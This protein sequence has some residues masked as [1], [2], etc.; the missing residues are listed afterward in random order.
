MLQELPLLLLEEPLPE[1]LEDAALLDEPELVELVEDVEPLLE[2][3]LELLEELHCMG[4]E[5][6]RAWHTESTPAFT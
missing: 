1:L 6:T 5:A 4:Y 2:L 3:E